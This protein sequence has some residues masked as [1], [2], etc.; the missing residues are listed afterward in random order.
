MGLAKTYGILLPCRK[1][2][3]RSDVNDNTRR[4]P[5][6]GRPSSNSVTML[7]GYQPAEWLSD[8]HRCAVLWVCVGKRLPGRN[9]RAPVVGEQRQRSTDS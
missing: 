2:Q 5:T 4:L 3:N 8:G 6:P 9:A 1:E 7:S